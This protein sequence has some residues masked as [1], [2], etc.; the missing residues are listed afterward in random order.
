VLA[1]LSELGYLAECGG[2]EGLDNLYS[3]RW[4]QPLF[5][6]YCDELKR[7]GLERANNFVPPLRFTGGKGQITVNKLRQNAAAPSWIG[8]ARIAG[9]NYEIRAWQT[10]DRSAVNLSFI[11]KR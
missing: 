9:K 6:F 1:C 8:S 4:Y 2:R 3:A 10:P 7:A 11:P 5:P